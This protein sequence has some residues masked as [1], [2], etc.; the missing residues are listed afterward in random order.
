MQLCGFPAMPVRFAMRNSSFDLRHCFVIRHSSFVIG[1]CLWLILVASPAARVRATDFEVQF[2]E[3][4]ATYRLGDYA[5]AVKAFRESAKEQPAAGTLQNLGN[6]EWKL[7][8]TGA[9]ILT[10][11]QTV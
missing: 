6:A 8:H 4:L 2:R 9:A 1:L 7:G 10:W 3:G 5:D 11:E